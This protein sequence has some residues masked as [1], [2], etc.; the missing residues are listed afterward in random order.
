MRSQ[1]ERSGTR[2][3]IDN[4]NWTSMETLRRFMPFPYP[5]LIEQLFSGA[6]CM[7]GA[8]HVVAQEKVVAL[9]REAA[10]PNPPKS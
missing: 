1:T 7:E 4:Q 9:G 8:V 6:H 5:L 2:A 10:I 3:T